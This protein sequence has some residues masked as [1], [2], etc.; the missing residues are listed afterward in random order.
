MDMMGQR[1]IN[2]GKRTRICLK[3]L[4]LFVIMLF[5]NLPIVFALQ[6]SSITTTDVTDSSATISWTTDEGANSVVQFGLE[7]NG[8]AS[9]SDNVLTTQ[10]SVELQGLNSGSDYYYSVESSNGT[11]TVLDTNNEAYYTFTTLSSE[12]NDNVND[13]STST[14]TTGPVQLHVS[15]PNI[16]AGDDVTVNGSATIGSEVRLFVNDGYFSKKNIGSSGLFTFTNVPLVR[17][18]TNV[19]S[20][21][22]TGPNGDTTNYV[23]EVYSDNERPTLDV[24]PFTEHVDANTV[25]LAG[26]VSEEVT[27]EIFKHTS[28]SDNEIEGAERDARSVFE[29]EGSAFE[30]EVQLDEGANEIEIRVTDAAGWVIRREITVFSDTESPEITAEFEKGNAYY[31]NRAE[32]ALHGTTEPGSIVSLYIYRPLGYEYTPDFSSAKEAVIADADGSFTFESVSFERD[33]FDVID[34]DNYSPPQIP[35]GLEAASVYPIESI[36]QAQDFTYYVYLIAQDRTGKTDYWQQM[37]TIHTCYS[38]NFDFSITDI[39][40]FQKPLRLD[41]GLLDEG[42]EVATTVFEIEYNGGGSSQV[43]PATGIELRAPVQIT[44]VSFEKAC[45]QDMLDDE[46]MAL[47]C[48]ILP[49]RPQVLANPSKT[50]YYLTWDLLSSDRLSERDE[51]FWNDFKERNIV[52][53]LKINVNYQEFDSLGN[54]GDSKTQ[55]SCYDLGYFVDIP[56]D[57]SELIP[58]WLADDG[59]KALNDTINVID[60]ILPVLEKV[61]LVTGISCF[62]SI[63]LKTVIRFARIFSAKAEY[64]QDLT[65]EDDEDKKCPLDQ[66]GLYLEDTLKNWIEI[67]EHSDLK[68]N[69]NPENN[70]F[71]G[72]VGDLIMNG[73]SME[74]LKAYVLE[75]KCDTTAGL[76]KAETALDQVYRWTCDRFLCREVPARWTQDKKKIEVDTVVASQKECTVTSSGVPLTKIENCQQF[77]REN[78]RTVP[79]GRSGENISTTCYRD[80][81]ENYYYFDPKNPQNTLERTND[82]IYTLTYVGNT[83]NAIG[84]QTSDLIAYKRTKESDQFIVGKQQSCRDIC[85]STSS[86]GFSEVTDGYTAVPGKPLQTGGAC[87][88]Q[89]QNELGNYDFLGYYNESGGDTQ[90]NAPSL[91]SN[92]IYA[93]YTNDCFVDIQENELYQCVCEETAAREVRNVARTALKVESTGSSSG[94]GS[95]VLGALASDKKVE[96]FSYRQDRIFKDSN[97]GKGTEYPSWR[98]YNLRDMQSAFGAN[99]VLDLFNINNPKVATINPHSQFLGAWQTVCLSTIRAQIV[100]L[101][102]ILV[103]LQGCIEQAKYTGFQDAGMCKTLFSQHVCGLIYKIISFAG[104]TCSPIGLKDVEKGGLKEGGTFEELGQ[105]VSAGSSSIQESMQGSIDDL[106]SDYGNAHLTEYFA[107]GAQG[108][109]ESICMAAFGFDWPIGFDFVMDTAYSTSFVSSASVFPA[110]REFSNYNLQASTAVYNYEIGEVIFPG[111]KI[112]SYK[113]SLKCIGPEERANPGVLCGDQGCDC[114]N[115]QG[116][117]S[118]VAEKTKLLD[119]G[120]GGQLTQGSMFDVPIPSPQRVDSHF[121]YD[122]VLLELK[123]NE[124]EDP[125]NCFTEG[126]RDG[127]FY[128]PITDVTPA[129]SLSCQVQTT[130]GQFSCPEISSLFYGEGF[131][132]LEDPYV[133]CYDKNTGLY[134]SCSTPNI[135]I[136]DDQIKIKPHVFTDGE[137]YCLDV[138]VTGTGIDYPVQPQPTPTGIAGPL[139]SPITI[140]TVK[141]EMFSVGGSQNRLTRNSNIQNNVNCPA[142]ISAQNSGALVNTGSSY[143]FDY[144]PL[145]AGGFELKVPT[146]IDIKLGSSFTIRSSDKKLLK[147]SNPVHTIEEINSVVFI[148]QG[149]EISNVLGS[150]SL[151]MY[152]DGA[153]QCSYS[154]SPALRGSSSSSN[155][156]TITV[157]TTLMHKDA[158]GGCYSAT[159]P[160]EDVPT[161]GRNSATT[162]IR[163]Q[164]Q[165]ESAIRASEIFDQFTA[166][167]YAGVQQ[168]ATEMMLQNNGYREEAMGIF[169]YVASTIAPNPNWILERKSEVVQLLDRF[170]LR[171]DHLGVEVPPFTDDL[172]AKGEFQKVKIYLCSIADALGESARYISS[173]DKCPT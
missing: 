161:L 110:L 118:F 166:K 52:F 16:V 91:G 107:G 168:I 39:A 139:Q 7:T 64:I 165:A 15:H 42:R 28:E 67:K 116:V 2:Q 8:L 23:G 78:P 61:I 154:S 72:E 96:K 125:N 100:M 4:T 53:P 101:R 111:C 79:V 147:G 106:Q 11:Q 37:I 117:S 156:N 128:F 149:M 65:G 30:T 59:M 144:T 105:L 124:N 47:G 97:G 164:R 51:N 138:K 136:M 102:S 143:T 92:K 123:L 170:F 32:S 33:L 108:F 29:T 83:V 159:V 18:S 157:R 58:D 95:S 98:Y 49:S 24:R 77:I 115:T 57:S 90:V 38:A 113:T 50:S 94:V 66:N 27:I 87:Y 171:K 89:V 54:Q 153:T 120:T 135:F 88:K 70:D 162:V 127:K 129:G 86:G 155:T 40:K 99:Y 112:D 34:I 26:S 71:P 104:S 172:R 103:G 73:A 148:I 82:G 14:Q 93:G 151:V 130:S 74:D 126:H 158:L 80:S 60:K 43:D 109:S 6:I 169:Y 55:T 3:F 122:H 133:T 25:T 46:R 132:Y 41:P 173:K 69:Q 5:M 35:A 9:V 142:S 10:H 121:R 160:V 13:D 167:N 76:W 22:S 75:E 131:A 84:T 44:S 137:G 134:G 12:T 21:E 36:A 119:G 45:T 17:D 141:E 81:E 19:I 152:S 1:I 20:L 48:K 68:N 85:R 146:G 114:V 145:L 140:G 62:V 150:G 63:G 163:V 31:Q 56:L